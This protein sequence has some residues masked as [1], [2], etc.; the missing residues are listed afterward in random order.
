MAKPRLNEG[1]IAALA[2][3]THTPIDVVK[4]LYNE[5]LA[6]LESKSAVKK[7]IEI[8]AG[9]RVQERLRRPRSRLANHVEPASLPQ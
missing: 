9:R 1:T 4:H 8:I 3:K 6:D 2:H 5:E 7:F